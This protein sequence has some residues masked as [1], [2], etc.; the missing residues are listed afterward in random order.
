MIKNSV[1]VNE[2]ETS[3]TAEVD[4]RYCAKKRATNHI[5]KYVYSRS[6][7]EI[8]FG[9]FPP[10]LL[11]PYISSPFLSLPPFFRY[12]VRSSYGFWESTVSFLGGVH[13]IFMCLFRGVLLVTANVILFLVSKVQKLKLHVTVFPNF[14]SGA[15]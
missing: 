14:I 9:V 15:F 13:G 7:I 1:N 5:I 2:T 12:A 6:K 3:R 11:F 8:Y 4:D 10:L